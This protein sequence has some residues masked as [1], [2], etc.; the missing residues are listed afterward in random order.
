MNFRSAA[1]VAALSLG[2][3]SS[4]ASADEVEEA[5]QLALEAYQ[6]GDLNAAKEEIDFASQLISQMKAAGLS[7][8]LPDAMEGWTRQDEATGNAAMGFM[9][10]GSIAN[11]TYTRDNERVE[12]QLMANNQMVAAMSGLFGNP[13]LMGAQGEVKRIK[14]QKVLVNQSGELQALIDKRIFVQVSGRAPVEIKEEYF[15][16]IDFKGLKDF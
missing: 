7:E 6:E 16:G 10:G 12:I 1:A 14:R 11:A 8:F 2:I 15:S 3:L 9:G 5:L 13:A 4:P